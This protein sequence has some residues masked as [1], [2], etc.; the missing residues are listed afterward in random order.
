MSSSPG[1]PDVAARLHVATTD[2]TW[3]TP[4][5]HSVLPILLQHGAKVLGRALASPEEAGRWLA[6][7]G[8]WGVVHVRVVGAW[9]EVLQRWLEHDAFR[10]FLGTRGVLLIDSCTEAGP[11][12]D[13]LLQ[14]MHRSL[15][16]HVPP[17]R[18]VLL[19]QNEAFVW[20]SRT[21]T[22]GGVSTGG[23]RLVLFHYWLART[24]MHVQRTPLRAHLVRETVEQP[25]TPRRFLCLNH[26]LRP[27]RAAI[28]GRLARC[29]VL[30]NSLVSLGS[31][32]GVL[33]EHPGG[34][35]SREELFADALRAMPSCTD[36]IL[37]ATAVQL[38]AALEGAV[39]GI[40]AGRHHVGRADTLLPDAHARTA[41]SIVAETEMTNHVRRFTEKTLKPLAMGHPFVL[42]GNWRTL[43]LLRS[44]GF[45]TF[46]PFVNETYDMIRDDSDRLL[47][48]LEEIERLARMR[49]EVFHAGIRA[50]EHVVHHNALHMRSRMPAVSAAQV[51]AMLSALSDAANGA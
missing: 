40:A 29:G 27:H 23:M 13:D 39:D 9:W 33:P 30:P 6:Q 37:A 34:R 11:F 14:A 43:E 36:D 48:V 3:L 44:Y 28:V 50:M 26:A 46:S 20:Q 21:R 16:P 49:D 10:R 1:L 22:E 35:R 5:R 41:M 18:V 38:P 24:L 15:A 8:G 7:C 19:F 17:T 31:G 2:A 25:G 47:A 32:T 42:A 45:R 51:R 12:Y 4:G